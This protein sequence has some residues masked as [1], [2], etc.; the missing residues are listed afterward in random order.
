ML[1][2]VAKHTSLA[3]AVLN[4]AE[5]SGPFGN[6]EVGPIKPLSDLLWRQRPYCT[7]PQKGKDL[8]GQN[9]VTKTIPRLLDSGGIES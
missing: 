4:W 7:F 8:A 2:A 3:T 9:V 1:S 6:V 5:P